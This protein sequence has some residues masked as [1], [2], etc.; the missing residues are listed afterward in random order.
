MTAT[1]VIDP[2]KLQQFLAQARPLLER[3]RARDRVSAPRTHTTALTAERLRA[4]LAR[5]R[6]AL[7]E[8]RRAGAFANPWT[9]AGLKHNEVRIASVLSWLLDP[10]GSHG[11]GDTYARALW[12]RLHDS[13]RA[14]FPIDGLTRV[15]TEQTPLGD[16]VNRV[17]LVLEGRGFLIFIEAKIRAPLR[18]RQLEDYAEALAKKAGHL[19]KK[20]ALLL[21]SVVPHPMPK[22]CHHLTWRD[23]ARA[24]RDVAATERTRPTYVTRLATTFADHIDKLT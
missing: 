4:C 7:T 19:G 10:G 15:V 5:I 13:G 16:E 24:I 23:V 21:L 22:D 18:D 1:A 3:M 8:A 6:P 12:K 2:T 9:I 14:L 20:S 11:A 17:D